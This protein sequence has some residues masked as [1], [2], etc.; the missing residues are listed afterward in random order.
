MRTSYLCLQRG[1]RNTIVPIRLS[2]IN[3]PHLLQRIDTVFIERVHS[4]I[5][6][7]A[8]RSDDALVDFGEIV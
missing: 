8:L 2:T 5:P 6:Q 3:F 4:R 7:E 1:H